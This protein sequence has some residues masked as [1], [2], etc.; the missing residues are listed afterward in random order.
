MGAG[1]RGL[2]IGQETCCRT[3]RAIGSIVPL[4]RM[5]GTPH[6]RNPTRPTSTP[7]KMARATNNGMP[8]NSDCSSWTKTFEE[9][10]L[11]DR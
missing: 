1:V 11:E 8:L 10:T 3:D 6:D 7:G 9:A 2:G 4:K 5:K